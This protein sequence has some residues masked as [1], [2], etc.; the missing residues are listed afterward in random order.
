MA[1]EE[2]VAEQAAA[3]ED[4]IFNNEFTGELFKN[5]IEL[6]ESK[7]LNFD[8]TVE[9]VERELGRGMEVNMVSGFQPGKTTAA[10]DEI[11]E[12]VDNLPDKPAEED[13]LAAFY[14]MHLKVVKTGIANLGKNALKRII[15]NTL[16][17]EFATKEYRPKLNTKEGQIEAEVAYHFNEGSQKRVLLRLE[18]EVQAVEEAI[19]KEEDDLKKI[20]DQTDSLLTPEAKKLLANLED[21]NA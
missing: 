2:L 8:N 20:N 13:F 19:A 18:R 1:N 12:I 15:L 7:P 9:A 14:E 17:G 10:K 5:S 4:T 3:K 11:D 16:M 21:E 6:L